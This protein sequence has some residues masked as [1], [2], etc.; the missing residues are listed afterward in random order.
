[1]VL[2]TLLPSM[3]VSKPDFNHEVYIFTYACKRIIALFCKIIISA[4][5][6]SYFFLNSL[7]IIEWFIHYETKQIET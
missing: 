4:S 3:H 7:F 5:S 2:S 1:M 6:R